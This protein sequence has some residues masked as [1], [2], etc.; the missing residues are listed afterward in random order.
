MV[1]TLTAGE[2]WLFCA[3]AAALLLMAAVVPFLVPLVNF[4]DFV[5]MFLALG[6]FLVL[7]RRRALPLWS[8]L[9]VFIVFIAHAAGVLGLF[10]TNPF[11]LGP[12]YDKYMHFL[13][14]VGFTLFFVTL[15]PAQKR[16]QRFCLAFL[17]LMGLAALG[18]VMEFSGSYFLGFTKGGLIATGRGGEI[19]G[20]PF[21]VYDPYFDLIFNL[22]GS[23][24][25]LGIA[26][27]LGE[28]WS[29][30]K[31]TPLKIKNKR[32]TQ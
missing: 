5:F 8:Y 15:L 4:V 27:L 19:A 2:R 18:K 31:R 23:V 20:N 7:A 16:W 12:G 30:A 1:R 28:R 11:G 21:D 29:V 14:G 9:A 22:I 26:L 10:A 25:G 3:A 32:T 17:C 6:V 13:S 24:V